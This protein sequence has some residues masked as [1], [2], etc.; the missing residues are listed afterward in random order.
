VNKLCVPLQYDVVCSRRFTTSYSTFSIP[1]K[2][3]GNVFLQHVC[4]F[5]EDQNVN[6]Q[7]NQI[8]VQEDQNIIYIYIYIYTYLYLNKYRDVYL[9]HQDLLNYRKDFFMLVIRQRRQSS[10]VS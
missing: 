7:C 1:S 3:G 4:H 2:N 10:L 9:R 8:T 5:P 6:Y